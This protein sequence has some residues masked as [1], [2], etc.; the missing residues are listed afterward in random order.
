MDIIHPNLSSLV[1]FLNFLWLFW[2]SWISSIS[3]NLEYLGSD[4]RRGISR[5]A[6]WVLPPQGDLPTTCRWNRFGF[7]N[8]LIVSP[9]NLLIWLAGETWSGEEDFL[10]DKPRISLS[11]VGEPFRRRQVL[12]LPVLIHHSVSVSCSGDGMLGDKEIFIMW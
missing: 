3:K 11:L 7:E 2:P 12:L 1:N 5:E 8:L 9:S 10:L 4:K 6:C